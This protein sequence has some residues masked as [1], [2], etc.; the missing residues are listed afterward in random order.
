[1]NCDGLLWLFCINEGVLFSK[2]RYETHKILEDSLYL[3]SARLPLTLNRI[4]SQFVT[5]ESLSVPCWQRQ[6]LK[7]QAHAYFSFSSSKSVACRIYFSIWYTHSLAYLGQKG[8]SWWYGL[9]TF[10]T[11]VEF[12]CRI[13][14]SIILLML[15]SFS[16]CMRKNICRGLPNKHWVCHSLR[17]K[18]NLT[19]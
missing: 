3:Q 5:S 8:Y 15:P 4:Y 17:K 6:T 13:D 16:Q 19:R 10:S 7:W 12:C 2:S 14:V 11:T 1:M 9:F 18:Q